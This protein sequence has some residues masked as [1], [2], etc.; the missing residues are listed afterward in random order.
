MSDNVKVALLVCATALLC[1]AA[2]IWFGPYQ[3][4][5]RAGGSDWRDAAEDCAGRLN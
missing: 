1:V 5:V 3:T 2:L 4:C